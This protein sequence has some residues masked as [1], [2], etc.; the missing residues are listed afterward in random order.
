MREIL[1]PAQVT[2]ADTNYEIM[3]QMYNDDVITAREG[4]YTVDFQDRVEQVVDIPTA[5]NWIK[6]QIGIDPFI[7]P[8]K[9]YYIGP[10]ADSIIAEVIDG[11]N[12]EAHSIGT[13]GSSQ[14]TTMMLNNGDTLSCKNYQASVLTNNTLLDKGTAQLNSYAEFNNFYAN[15]GLVENSTFTIRANFKFFPTNA[16]RGNAILDSTGTFAGVQI[17]LTGYT[18]S[19]HPAIRLITISVTTFDG[20]LYQQTTSYGDL[21]DLTYDE[22]NAGING[23][24]GD[25]PYEINPSTFGGGYGS[26]VIRPSDLID[27]PEAPDIDAISTGLLTIFKPTLSQVQS[28]GDYLWSSAFDVDTLKK[29]FGD[30]MEA[31]IGLSIVPVNPPAAGSKNVKIGDIDTGISM[32]YLNKQFVEKDLG[33]LTIDPYIGSFMDYAPYTKISIYLPYIGFRQLAP[34]DVM[35]CT[36][37]IKYIIDVLT[38]GCNA[39]INVSGKGAIYQFNGSCIANVPLSAINYSGAIQNAVSA[40]GNLATVGA[41]IATGQAPITGMGIMGLATQAANTAVNSKPHIQHSG[42][43]GGA[44]GLCSVQYAYAVIERPRLSTPANYNGFIGNTLNVTMNIGACDGLTVVES[45]HLDNVLCTENER[46]ELMSLLKEGVIVHVP[47]PEP[48]PTPDT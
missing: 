21:I 35:G 28:L 27:D 39:V 2:V 26:G 46:D 10:T 30:P 14:P 19:L 24:S 38:G 31:I 15:I 45:I 9:Q 1:I 43:M 33:S 36:L 7:I 40:I 48:E 42:N 44:S 5:R 23:F 6:N 37:N 41:G 25:N 13:A 29:L 11:F 20:D 8:M 18:R 22:L 16:I 17:T 4:T 34:E 47:P 3:L 32:S 12:I